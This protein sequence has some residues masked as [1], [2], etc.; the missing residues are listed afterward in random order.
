MDEKKKRK[1]SFGHEA[2][3]FSREIPEPPPP[4]FISLF[5]SMRQWLIS[6]CDSEHPHKTISEYCFLLYETQGNVL[7]GLVGYNSYVDHDTEIIQI[8]FKPSHVFFELPKNE[9]RDLSNEEV[10]KRILNELI[11]FIGTSGFQNS[12][13]AKAESITTNFAGK[14]WPL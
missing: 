14:I 3:K 1:I 2:I 5:K 12:F 9:Y 7:I 6:I 11:E 10:K 8:D 4:D 13:L